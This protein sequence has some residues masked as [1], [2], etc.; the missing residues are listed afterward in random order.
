[1]EKIDNNILNINN[2]AKANANNG[3]YYNEKGILMCGKCHTP[4]ET[5]TLDNDDNLTIKVHCICECEK[6]AL[7]EEKRKQREIEHKEYM[8]RMKNLSFRDEKSKK[9]T[10]ATDDG[11]N[12]VLRIQFPV[13][14]KSYHLKTY[15][16]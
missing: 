4:K 15:K 16:K 9:N 6:E 5:Y 2:I 3:D 10:F 14:R 1:M 7:I 8:E 13:G 11:M 12:S